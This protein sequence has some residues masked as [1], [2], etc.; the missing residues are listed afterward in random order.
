MKQNKVFKVIIS[1][2]N[3]LLFSG[4]AYSVSLP[5]TEGQITIL[6]GHQ[7]LI[8]LLK[9]GTITISTEF[10]EK[11]IEVEKGLVEVSNGQA[12]ILV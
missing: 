9:K 4:D 8:T 3:E 11:K 1:K 12:T 5:G 6:A 10:E 2:V 7:A